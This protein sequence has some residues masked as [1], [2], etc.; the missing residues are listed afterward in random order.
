[1]KI[2]FKILLMLALVVFL[3][4]KTPV[5]SAASSCGGASGFTTFLSSVI[6]LEDF[7][8]YWNDIFSKNPCQLS[9]IL[10][11]DERLDVIAETLR[12]T[13]YSNVTST[14]LS[15][16][17]SDLVSD[18][19]EDSSYSCDT[20]SLEALKL[21]YKV[22]KAE[23]YF[24]RKANFINSSA[25]TGIESETV[26]NNIV[27]T[28]LYDSFYYEM[29][30]RY[31]TDKKWF[32]EPDFDTYFKSWVTKYEENIPTYIICD[33][34]WQPLV[35]KWTE[36]WDKYDAAK[37][38]KAEEK[39]QAEADAA[40][41]AL[42]AKDAP[43]GDTKGFFAKHFGFESSGLEEVSKLITKSGTGTSESS[44]TSTND[45][46]ITSIYQS[47]TDLLSQYDTDLTEAQL[48]ANYKAMY[49]EGGSEIAKSLTA[50]I[51][52]LN[53]TLTDTIT[54]LTTEVNKK[55]HKVSKKQC[56]G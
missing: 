15:V 42:T 10:A 47:Y 49:G 37:A 35:D 29:Q 4:A 30:D 54:L 56:N 33:S 38:K 14:D 16:G 51:T 45:G 17:S 22:T 20:E 31:V 11:V 2:C 12:Q 6:E 52:D 50:L 32:S 1:M 8:V 55:A 23:L 34:T 36:I 27:E 39:K 18:G 19:S 41:A 44:S 26:I 48:L 28:Y 24:V 7:S 5:V 9:D 21:E 46:S 3:T 53:T 43:A 40:A 13:Y 25:L